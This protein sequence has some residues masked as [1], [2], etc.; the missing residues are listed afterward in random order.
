MHHIPSLPWWTW[1]RLSPFALLSSL[2]LPNIKIAL[3]PADRQNKAILITKA[4]TK[5]STCVN[6]TPTELSSSAQPMQHR[7]NRASCPYS[8]LSFVTVTAAIFIVAIPAK[9]TDKGKT[10]TNG[11]PGHTQVKR[12]KLRKHNIFLHKNGKNSQQLFNYRMIIYRSIPPIKY[13]QQLFYRNFS[14]HT[15]LYTK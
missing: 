8:L 11:Q 6:D 15:F 9:H 1:A 13:D 3:P 2:R 4:M 14:F 10:N 5:L 7:Y 12:A